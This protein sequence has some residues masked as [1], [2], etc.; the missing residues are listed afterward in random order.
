MAAQ[1]KRWILLIIL[2]ILTVGIWFPTLRR[3]YLRWGRIPLPA[4]KIATPVVKPSVPTPTPAIYSGNEKKM[5]KME[6]VIPEAEEWEWGRDPFLPPRRVV[7]PLSEKETPREVKKP[8]FTLRGI[9]RKGDRMI[10]VINENVVEEGQM[11]EGYRVSNIYQDRV[12][13]TQDREKI[14]L[15]FEN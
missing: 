2:V 3:I 10:A 5:V 6:E 9:F 13:L 4:I 7:T 12:I 14:E 1:N 15:K 8:S 11:V